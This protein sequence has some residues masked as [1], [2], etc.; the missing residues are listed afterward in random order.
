MAIICDWT[1]LGSPA[2]YW[3]PAPAWRA[4]CVSHIRP[5]PM[6]PGETALTRMPCGARSLAAALLSPTT[7]AF[8][9][10]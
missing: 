7:A 1:V 8:E 2:K 5:G 4:T 3:L 10:E 9:A 6:N